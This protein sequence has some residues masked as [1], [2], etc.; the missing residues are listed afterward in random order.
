MNTFSISE[1][2]AF[3][4]ETFKKNVSFFVI[5]LVVLA[6]VQ[7]VGAYI[8]LFFKEEPMLGLVLNLVFVF[9]SMIVSLGVMRMTL[10]L[11]DGK[12][13]NF[14]DFYQQYP[15]LLK[16]IGTGIIQ[17]LIVFAGFLLL[18]IPGIYLSVKLG[19]SSYVVVD[20]KVGP[21]DAIKS[22]YEMTKGNWW[23]IAF[24][25]LVSFFICLAGVLA[26]LVGLFV[27]IP[28]TTLA[29]A[30]VYRK[31]SGGAGA[32]TEP[33]PAEPVPAIPTSAPEPAAPALPQT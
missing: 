16:Y 22:S 32:Q 14:N 33:V 25:G 26:L 17:G 31:L 27:A 29:Y 23:N 19:F 9:A 8:S 2:L 3:G 11:V 28:V 30:Y 10:D 15:L 12:K 21:F 5:V 20:K 1:A 4:W 6:V 24:L 18:I 13:P 7:G